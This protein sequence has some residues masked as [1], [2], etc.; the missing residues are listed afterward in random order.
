MAV[1][2]V[3]IWFVRK[4]GDETNYYFQPRGRVQNS[5]EN[6]GKTKNKKKK[7]REN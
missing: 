3:F 4:K 1:F 2:S 7:R 6:K 5:K